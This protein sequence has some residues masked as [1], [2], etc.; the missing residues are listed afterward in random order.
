MGN[1][2]FT[3]PE[4]M[5][6]DMDG[7]LFQTETLLE[8]VHVRL[9]RQLREEELYLGEMPPAEKLLSSLGML[10]EDIWRRV[11]PDGSDA[12][13][14]RADELMLQYELE[15]LDSGLGS[16]YPYV[17]T[18]LQELQRRGIKLFVASNGL[19]HYVKGVARS[20]G[21]DRYFHGLYSAGEYGTLSKVDLV[22]GL[23]KDYGIRTAW[24]IGDRSSDVEAGVKNG[25]TVI[26]CDYAGFGKKEELEGADAVIADFRELIRYIRD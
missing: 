23:L 16:L 15:G 22:A 9:F 17:E 14:R 25:L 12:A 2:R 19:E 1:G 6:F 11:M 4:A 24:M 21:I 10:L 18:T 7:T 20:K 3:K 13:H 5:I 26:G 8:H